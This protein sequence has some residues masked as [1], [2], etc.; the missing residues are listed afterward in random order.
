[1]IDVID[2][3][4]MNTIIVN[5]L[6]DPL[7]GILLNFRSDKVEGYDEV[8]VSLI[9]IGYHIKNQERLHLDLKSHESLP[10]KP[11]VIKPP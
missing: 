8:V 2:D 3:E 5:L 7:V 6:N 9:G 11:S 4:A 1:M 10:A